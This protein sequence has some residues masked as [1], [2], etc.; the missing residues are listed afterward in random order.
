MSKFFIQVK[1]EFWECRAS[2]LRTPFV[3]AGILMTLLLLGIVPFQNKI[4][5]FLEHAKIEHHGEFQQG[6]HILEKWG[7]NTASEP[8][9]EYLT[10]GLA[11]LYSLFVLVLLLVLSFYF[12]DALYSDRRDQSILFWK[13]L[14]VAEH[15]TIMAKLAAGT[16]GAPLFYAAAAFATGV[17][18][19]LTLSLYAK[20]FW[21]L[22][23]PGL[24]PVL[25]V[26]L[27]STVGLVLGWV[28]L[29]IWYLPIFC[30]L[31]FT[32]AAAKKA[33]FLIALGVPLALVVLE[34]WVFG[35]RHLFTVLRDQ[36]VAG[37]YHLHSVAH[38]PESIGEHLINTFSSIQLWAG[39]AISA[40]FLVACSWLRHN[41]WEL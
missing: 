31:L 39:L 10:H 3:M 37:L 6:A 5:G 38:N 1:R 20:V 11:G 8:D 7:G 18:Y 4:G 9:L 26:F 13:S 19:L 17:F 30:W 41:R 36:T 15:K 27:T 34:A 29:V 22:P 23:L 33:P 28:L 12:A 24:G 16:M 2:F 40:G 25:A 35:T 21:N 32:S 14:P